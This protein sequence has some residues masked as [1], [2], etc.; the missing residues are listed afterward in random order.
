MPFFKPRK[1]GYKMTAISEICQN[2]F[3][4]YAFKFVQE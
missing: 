4:Y 1:D 2:I 3:D